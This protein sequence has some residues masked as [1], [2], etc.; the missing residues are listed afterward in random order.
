[1]MHLFCMTMTPDSARGVTVRLNPEA[2][3]RLARMARVEHRSVAA[4]L[5]MLVEREIAARDEAE[6][7]IRVYVAPELAGVPFGDPDRRSG[8]SDRAYAARRQTIDTL[9]GR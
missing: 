3:D 6:R 7:V 1:M 2:H 4:F 9:F 8:E 5:A